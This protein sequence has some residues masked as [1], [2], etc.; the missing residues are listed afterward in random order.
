MLGGFLNA[1]NPHEMD[2]MNSDVC[3]EGHQK[4]MFNGERLWWKKS[5]LWTKK[6]FEC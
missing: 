3:L 1:K 6:E 4:N 2:K 5:E